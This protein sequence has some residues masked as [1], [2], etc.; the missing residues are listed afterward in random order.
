MNRKRTALK[1]LILVS[2]AY[3]MVRM[4]HWKIGFTYFT[5]LSNLFA[6]CVVFCQLFRN[7]PALRALKFSATV[8]IGITFLMYL[9]VLGPMMPGGLLA[10]YGQDHCASL[11]LHLLT[12][13]LTIADFMSDD[14]RFPFAR[15]H[16]LY[17]ML[18]PIAYFAFILGLS[19]LGVTWAHGM[20]A[21]PYPFLNYAAPAGWFGIVPETAGQWSMGIGVF[22]CVVAMVA[23][24]LLA[25]FGLLAVAG[26]IR[27][28]R[29]A[30]SVL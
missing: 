26:M 17:A 2:T 23:L 4:W 5:Q 21:A 28:H 18:P 6:A 15:R 12:P 14:A 8:S 7:R 11:C 10:A 30:D 20:M 16:A 1:I 25:G 13:G 27:K 29:L 3:A 22:Y 9:T 19:R 24:F